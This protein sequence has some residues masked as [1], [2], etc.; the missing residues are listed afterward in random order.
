MDERLN[1]LSI[2]ARNCLESAKITTL[3]QLAATP[4]VSLL[5][6]RSFGKT[7]L[8]ECQRLLETHNMD[9]GMDPFALAIRRARELVD[10]CEQLRISPERLFQLC[11]E[12]KEQK[13]DA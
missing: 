9:G 11:A 12:Q 8:R 2:R 1:K 10:L 3:E 4:T 13:P 6:I 5:A 7:T